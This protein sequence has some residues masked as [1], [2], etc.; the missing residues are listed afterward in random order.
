MLIAISLLLVVFFLVMNAFF[1][2]AEF[3]LVR[4]RKSQIDVLVAEG[5]KKAL[6]AKKVTD[7]INAYLSACQLGITLA[8]LAL[9]WL[10]EPAVSKLFE[11]LF[12][13]LGLN[14][15]TA[16]A[17][18]VIIG[19]CIITMLH[20]VF[21]E[22]VPKSLAIFSTEKYALATA[23]LLYFF[24]HITY[25]IMVLFNST[26]NGILKLLGHSTQEEAT[27]SNEEILL[28]M[29]ESVKQGQIDESQYQFVD[30][31][32][33]LSDKDAETIM[34]PRTDMI[35]LYLEDNIEEHLDTIN[36]S[37]FTRY[38]VCKE[39]KDHLVGFIHIKDLY[40][41]RDL[42]GSDI[43][44][45]IRKLNA[46]PESLPIGRLLTLFKA[47]KTKIAVVVDEHGGTSG[48]VTLSDVI[49]EI[50]GEMSD[51][52]YHDEIKNFTQIAE[53]KWLFEGVLEL[54]KCAEHL[55]LRIEDD[56]DSETIGG[57]LLALMEKIPQ[58]GDFCRYEDVIFTI[59]EMEGLRIK[60]IEAKVLRTKEAEQEKS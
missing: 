10:G 44:P 20:I 59:R 25:P 37:H 19:F 7:N 9:G 31:I 23:R 40:C 50:V 46:I 11:P 8:S 55:G 33:D 15:A 18:A 12:D 2:A 4:V 16:S 45:L 27:M 43:T 52:Y 13:K 54:D 36:N 34:T 53:N 47:K 51:E 49:D 1:V 57:F 58:T 39:D 32:F 42:G 29:G 26:T 17:V 3:A 48:I 35:C 60:L 24:Y 22:L 38:P 30:N 56:F 6:V 14:A 21:G 41:L 5:N 28:M